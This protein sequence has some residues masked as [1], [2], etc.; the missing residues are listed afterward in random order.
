MHLLA[1]PFIFGGLILKVYNNKKKRLVPHKKETENDKEQS[2]QDTI[3]Q[4]STELS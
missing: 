3:Y 4:Q 2:Q 1:A